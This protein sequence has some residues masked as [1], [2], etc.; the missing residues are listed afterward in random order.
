[1]TV[2]VGL[3]IQVDPERMVQALT[4]DNERLMAIAE[5]A[6]AKGA[7]HHRFYANVDGSE[8]LV[9]DEWETAEGFQQFF[10]ENPDIGSMMGEAG[11][12]GEP[13]AKFW[14]ELDTPDKF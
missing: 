6:K 13:E 4:S 9:I 5:R 14:R 3:R 7:L 10:A 12:T 2:I 11:M 8:A 1:M